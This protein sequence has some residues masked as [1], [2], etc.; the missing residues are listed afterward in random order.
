MS[1]TINFEV[2]GEFVLSFRNSTYCEFSDTSWEAVSSYLLVHNVNATAVDFGEVDQYL[3]CSR[4]KKF[5]L[6]S[7]I[8]SDS[9]ASR[10]VPTSPFIPR[11]K[12]CRQVA[13]VPITFCIDKM[14][15]VKSIELE[16]YQGDRPIMGDILRPEYF[17]QG[18]ITH[19]Y[20]F[21][22]ESRT[23]ITLSRR[24]Y[25]HDG[26]WKEYLDTLK[27]P[28]WNNPLIKVLP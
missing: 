25:S 15:D 8:K 4:I 18:C 23:D 14:E 20:Q 27:L 26:S 28:V 12:V 16:F 7:L 11:V 5:L 1:D 10:S 2:Q 19:E 24:V 21:F 17:L 6:P 22:L 9:V 13:Y 3:D